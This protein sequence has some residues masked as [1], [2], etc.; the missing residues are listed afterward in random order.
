[1]P[2][3]LSASL[4]TSVGKGAAHKLRAAKQTPAVI[5]GH[6]RQPQP[7]ALDTRE[8][9]RLLEHISFETTV[10]ELSL[11]GTTSRTLIRDIQRHPYRREILH[12]DFLELVAGE[13]I[14]VNLPIVLVGTAAGVR[15]D[16]GTLDQVLR[17]L[18]VEVDP[19]NI[20][21]H[22]DVDVSELQLNDSIHVRDITLP[23][24]IEVLD[25]MDATICVVAPPRVEQEVV[26]PVEG[27]EPLTEPELIRKA[28]D[29][30]EE[31]EAEKK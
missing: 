3:T 22:I 23:P 13:L 17:E 29:E 19:A 16:G 25:D 4:R 15:N 20:P 14:E 31:G 7:L 30:E 1:M 8:L 10:V 27:T 2:A 9:E 5:Y 26:A 6:H 28:K 24:G 12:V 21:N 11:S 18:R